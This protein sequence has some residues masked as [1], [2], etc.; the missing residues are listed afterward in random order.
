MLVSG[1]T[2]AF[3]ART[4]FSGVAFQLGPGQR[5]AVVGPNAAGKTTLL[6]V[7]AGQLDADAGEVVLPKGSRIALHDQR[8]PLGRDISLGG[9]VAEGLSAVEEIEAQLKS[10]EKRMAEGDYGDATMAEYQRAQDALERG[11]GYGWRTWMER[12]LRGLGMGNADLDRPLEGFS[13]GELTRA[14]LARSLVGGPDVLLLDEPT[15]HLD[16]DAVEW[17]EGALN[18]LAA[19]VVIISHDRWFLESTA[20]QILEI[21]QGRAKN[22]AMGYSAFRRERA[23]AMDRQS[24]ESE[25]QAKEIERLERFVSRWSAGTKS[26]QATSR[27]K[28]LDKIE[29][30]LPPTK[31]ESMAFGFPRTERPSRIVAEV[32]ALTLKI[33]DRTLL[34]TVGLVVER[35]QRIAIMG[36]N[37]AGKTTFIETLLGLRQPDG[38]RVSL[39]HKVL[40]GYFSQHASELPGERTIAEAILTGTNLTNTQARTLLGRF[41]FPG[42]MA[43]RKIEQL[44]GGERRRV[45][46][47]RL[48]AEGGNFLVLDEPTNHLD[49]ESREALEEALL[50]YDGTLILVSHDRA[51]IDLVATHTLSFEN[52][53]LRLRAGG[54]RDLVAA[55]ELEAASSAPAPKVAS[56]KGA[57]AQAEAARKAQRAPK[58]KGRRKL[59]NIETTISDLERTLGEVEAELLL[60]ATATDRNRLAD[61]GARHQS[62]EREIAAK[63][64]E[65]EAAAVDE[66]PLRAGRSS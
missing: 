15:N 20:T 37:G 14:S 41:L 58:P 2:K 26:R 51:L 64:G 54:Y 36:P 59:S 31:A 25:R 30:V 48:I 5:L 1:L 39:G 45:S 42:S 65:W 35:G 66:Q 56:P 10:L 16:L 60:P 23:L 38:G 22:W 50:A 11:G 21:E 47:V 52:E 7:I 44:S 6:R 43:D 57:A 28:A 55:H 62:L 49:I 13:G 18:D 61:L 3:G 40:P 9:Y 46:L 4:L 27:K 32:D 24:A 34:D 53:G 17:L 8:P 29:R 12:V 33:P 63:L 19:S